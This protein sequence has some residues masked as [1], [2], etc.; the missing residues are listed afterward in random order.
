MSPQLEVVSGAEVGRRIVLDG[1]LLIGRTV[2]GE[3]RV[4]DE[5]V[6]RRHARVSADAS[7][8]LTVEDLGSANGTWVNEERVTGSQ[9]LSE[10][11]RVRIGNTT[12]LVGAQARDGGFLIHAEG[13]TR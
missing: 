4:D 1:E 13:M 5:E 12:L 11:D 9:G 7:G 10:G 6:S 2:D 8:D 3:G